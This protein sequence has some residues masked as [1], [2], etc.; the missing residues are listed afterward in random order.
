L[1]SVKAKAKPTQNK[2]PMASAGPPVDARAAAAAA[3]AFFGIS[4]FSP[5]FAKALE[6][7]AKSDMARATFSF[8]DWVTDC[9][10]KWV[11]LVYDNRSVE[12]EYVGV[13]RSIVAPESAGSLAY[14]WSTAPKEKSASDI[15][16]LYARLYAGI[17]N[18]LLEKKKMPDNLEKKKMPDKIVMCEDTWWQEWRKPTDEGEDYERL[19]EF[20]RFCG[21]REA[22][23][24]KGPPPLHGEFAAAMTVAVVY[25]ALFA[26]T[27]SYVG[28]PAYEAARRR[29][30]EKTETPESI[31][32]GL[33]ALSD[34]SRALIDLRLHECKP[35]LSPS[36]YRFLVRM[37]R[38]DYGS[39]KN[40]FRYI[41]GL[42][43]ESG[44]RAR[45]QRTGTVAKI[46]GARE[47]KTTIDEAAQLVHWCAAHRF[48]VRQK[49]GPNMRVGVGVYVGDALLLSAT[50]GK[51][52]IV[53]ARTKY[54]VGNRNEMCVVHVGKN[55]SLTV[56]HMTTVLIGEAL[57]DNRLALLLTKTDDFLLQHASFPLFPLHRNGAR[58]NNAEG[59]LDASLKQ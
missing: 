29:S 38:T 22:S 26:C 10:G 41:S 8:A 30:A 52:R 7:A 58:M 37:L 56:D 55:S 34:A 20:S 15:Y 32:L 51:E 18:H 16:L 27:F 11:S 47:H 48:E 54:K 25:F 6:T 35:A 4:G 13:V 19:S 1:E 36:A 5:K 53:L 59:I 39:R 2:A 14:P 45:R 17:Y 12:S 3:V 28:L 24:P 44:P 46:G 21:E 42:T 57:D 49:L 31:P 40:V 43:G 23:D 9:K 50:H 33:I